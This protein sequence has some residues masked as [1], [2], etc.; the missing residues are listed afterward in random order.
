LAEA[1]L[2]QLADAEVGSRAALFA[3]AAA[4]LPDTALA[5]RFRAKAG[6]ASGFEL[7]VVDALIGLGARRRPTAEALAPLLALTSGGDA[8]ARTRAQRA[9]LLLAAAGA[10]VPAEARVAALRFG[11]GD[12]DAAVGRRLGLDLAADA[13][14]KGEAAL[15]ALDIA[16]GSGASGPKLADRIEIVRALREA[17]VAGWGL[18]VHEGLPPP[19][20]P[21]R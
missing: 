1:A 19:A 6:E 5:T 15:V 3:R 13:Q 9:V 16:L 8:A 11:A 17:G 21:G 7:A 18:W 2:R 14:A 4:A 10:P 20:A 12:G